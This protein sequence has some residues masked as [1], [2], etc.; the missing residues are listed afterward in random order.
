[1]PREWNLLKSTGITEIEINITRLPY[2]AQQIPSPS[3]IKI[4]LVSRSITISRFRSSINPDTDITF[5][6][7]IGKV[8]FLSGEMTVPLTSK[9]KLN[10]YKAGIAPPAKVKETDADAT[11]LPHVDDLMIIVKYVLP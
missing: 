6:Q 9:F 10:G 4:I 1:M 8:L 11:E 3:S 2:F 5:N 7:L